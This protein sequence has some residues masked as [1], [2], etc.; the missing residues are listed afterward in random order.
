MSD[1]LEETTTV[2]E[3]SAAA[4]ADAVSELKYEEIVA[5]VVRVDL[6]Q[7]DSMFTDILKKAVAKL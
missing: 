4:L 2:V 6:T 7:G 1:R 5:L 3:V